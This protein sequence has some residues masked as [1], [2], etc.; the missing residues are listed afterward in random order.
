MK[1]IFAIIFLCFLVS[2]IFLFNKINQPEIKK[3]DSPKL[4]QGP[5]PENCDEQYFRETGITKCNTSLNG[6]N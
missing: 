3:D 5:V 1:I 4:Y 6:D 2:G